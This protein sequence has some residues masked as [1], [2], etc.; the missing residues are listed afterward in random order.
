MSWHIRKAAA[1]LQ[2]AAIRTA[3]GWASSASAGS[4]AQRPARKE[5]PVRTASM[6]RNDGES[7]HFFVKLA[8]PADYLVRKRHVIVTVL[9]DQRFRGALL[10]TALVID[11]V[12]HV[13]QA[14]RG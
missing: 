6:R 4:T 3:K 10:E 13:K 8:E 14:P 12:A 9:Q 2:T 7:R 11:G 5:F 1:P